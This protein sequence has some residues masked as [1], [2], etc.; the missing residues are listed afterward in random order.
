MSVTS[1]RLSAATFGGRVLAGVLAA[2]GI[3]A[4]GGGSAHAVP[5]GPGPGTLTT[6]HAESAK[7]DPQSAP[8]NTAPR[9]V[10]R[11]DVP[12]APAGPDYTAILKPGPP[13]TVSNAEYSYIA[14]HSVTKQ[15][16]RANVSGGIAA[17]PV[18]AQYRLANDG[19][20]LQFRRAL[21]GALSTRGG[22][23]QIVVSHGNPGSLF[24][25]GLFAIDGRYCD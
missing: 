7:T 3:I 23:I 10:E 25:Y 24:D 18:P 12:T 9:T 8:D 17:L 1:S 6:Q 5:T 11:P 20:A 22:C 14:T 19:L 2:A 21:D 13:I 15:L 16:K 4:A